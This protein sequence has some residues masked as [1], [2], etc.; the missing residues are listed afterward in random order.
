MTT[1]TGGNTVYELR[2]D[3]YGESASHSWP[4]KGRFS[5]REKA[6]KRAEQIIKENNYHFAWRVIPVSRKKIEAM[7]KELEIIS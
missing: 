2:M 4:L 1:N 7:R 3:P 6:E 5:T